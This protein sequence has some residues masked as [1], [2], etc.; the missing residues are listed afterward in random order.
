MNLQLFKQKVIIIKYENVHVY[1][2][3]MFSFVLP[4][5]YFANNQIVN[6]RFLQQRRCRCWSSVTL[7]ALVGGYQHFR[8]LYYFH[9]PP[10]RFINTRN[11]VTTEDTALTFLY[12][13]FHIRK[14]SIQNNFQHLTSVN[15]EQR[16]NN[17]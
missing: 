8:G 2:V 15:R 6:I 5:S 11:L 14:L 1:N 12:C 4:H 3:V 7:C 17:Y 9:I 16:K 10:R 13:T